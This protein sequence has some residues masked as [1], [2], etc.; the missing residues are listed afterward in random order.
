MTSGLSNLRIKGK[1]LPEEAKEGSLK[2]LGEGGKQ[3]RK[4]QQ[5]SP[6][7]NLL[8]EAKVISS[9]GDCLSEKE[10]AGTR[11]SRSPMWSGFK[12]PEGR[13]TKRVRGSDPD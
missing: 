10:E 3:P 5:G 7:H 12:D 4:V 6:E 13:G 1:G 11:Q 2:E 8:V 9:G